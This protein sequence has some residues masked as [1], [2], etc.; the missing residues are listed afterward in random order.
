M[1]HWLGSIVENLAVMILTIVVLVGGLYLLLTILHAWLRFK[2]GS[3]ET[4]G[5]SSLWQETQA[6]LRSE[7]KKDD[8]KLTL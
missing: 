1:A 8:S 5:L 3:R 2:S 4:E 7:N 6:Q